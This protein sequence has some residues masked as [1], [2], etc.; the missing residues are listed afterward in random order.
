MNQT[1][2]N[3]PVIGAALP[4]ESVEHLRDWLFDKDRDLELQDFVRPQVL[5]SDWQE[6][7]ARYEK[8]LDGYQGRVGIHGLFFGL[9]MSV[10]DPEVQAIV[11]KRYLQ[12]LGVCEALGATQ[13]VVHSPFT[14]WHH[15]NFDNGGWLKDHLFECCHTV[16]A[17]VVKRA[18][19][20]GCELVIENIQDV[21]PYERVRLAESFDSNL[22][23]V[24]IDTGHAQWAHKATGAPPVD[25]FL[26]AAGKHLAHVHLQDADGFAD[27]HWLPGSGTILWPA[28]FE[29]L[30]DH[31]DKPRL[32]VEVL[33]KYHADIPACVARF[34]AE[35][36]AQ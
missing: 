29:A 18:E 5:E 33:G 14:L 32:V 4:I 10:A 12:G 36:L 1:N 27:R 26:K 34:E 9:D 28:F 2:D 13:M 15:G 31:A 30:R 21:D 35:G 23:R 19:N 25:Y 7:V 22:V 11:Q 16:L 24:S 20:I 3:L 17:P 8:L 6:I